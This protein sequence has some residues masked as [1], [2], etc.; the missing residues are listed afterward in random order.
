MSKV[1]T[2]ILIS[3]SYEYYYINFILLLILYYYNI[4]YFLATLVYSPLTRSY[5][6]V[7]Y[8]HSQQP[9]HQPGQS[10]CLPAPPT[11]SVSPSWVRLDR[12]ELGSWLISQSRLWDG[13]EVLSSPK[14]KLL[15]GLSVSVS[16]WNTGSAARNAPDVSESV[17]EAEVLSKSIYFFIAKVKVRSDYNLPAAAT[18]FCNSCCR[19]WWCWKYSKPGGGGG[20]LRMWGGG[21]R[22]CLSW[23]SASIFNISANPF[24]V[25][26]K[27]SKSKIHF[28]FHGFPP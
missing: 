15:P 21:G 17:W 14:W 19:W 13:R 2:W 24:C 6:P 5:N 20:C 28:S 16:V 25:S 3:S 12:T 22:A 26:R 7:H 10:W 8:Y 23:A 18:G 9:H 11:A 4:K 1:C 27:G